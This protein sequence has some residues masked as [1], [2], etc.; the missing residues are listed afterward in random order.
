ML[1]DLLLALNLFNTS[2]AGG[3]VLFTS[4][5]SCLE[6][7]ALEETGD[8]QR[9]RDAGRKARME[10]L[11]GEMEGGMGRVNIINRGKD[12]IT[13]SFVTTGTKFYP[14]RTRHQPP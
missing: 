1:C 5:V 8:G 12:C 13:S 14:I 4:Q 10:G 6:L 9:K 11:D 3:L 7:N 2:G